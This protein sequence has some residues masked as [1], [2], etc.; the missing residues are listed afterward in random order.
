MGLQIA[1][2]E[3]GRRSAMVNPPIFPVSTPQGFYELL[4]A[5]ASK[6]P[7]AMK[8]FATAH[9][10]F[11]PFGVWATSSP[12]TGS[13]AEERYNGLNSFVITDRSGAEHTVRSSLLPE[14]Q[15]VWVLPDDLAK[16]GPNFLEQE[17]TERPRGGPQ[18]WTMVVTVAYP[19]DPSAD[20]SKVWPEDRRT[21]E[22]GTLMVSTDRTRAERP[23]PRHQLL[24]RP[25]CRPVYGRRTTRFRPHGRPFTGS[26]MTSARP[27]RS[28]TP[29]LQ[30]TPSHDRIPPA[31]HTTAAPTALADG[32]LHLTML[33]I[34]IGM[35]ST[36]NPKYL[37][38]VSIHKPLGIAI[39]MLALIRLTVRLRYGTPPLPADLPE[40]T[41]LGA[42]LSHY[43][44]YV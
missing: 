17:I 21:V 10:E 32:D 44:L 37:T 24:I 30:G 25:S 35:V 16:R 33:F 2:P 31:L 29:G 20:T 40:P 18:R 41:K 43:A 5:S 7:D 28:T 22:I 9:P 1:T 39:L 27:R 15:P 19:G 8:T 36:V 3:G 42:G 6:D 11:A 12:W 14:A 38:L 13:Y 4:L 34:G 26:H 23:V